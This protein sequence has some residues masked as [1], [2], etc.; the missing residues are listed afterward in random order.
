MRIIY[1]SNG[2]TSHDWNFLDKLSSSDNEVWFLRLKDRSSDTETRELPVGVNEIKWIG[3]PNNHPSL[4]QM[5]QLKC[6]FEKILVKVRPDIIH[7][8]PIQSCAF[9]AVLSGF[10]PIVATSWGYDILTDAYLSR[11]M[12]WITEYTLSHCD[13]ILCD[14]N[15]V[16]EKIQEFTNLDS[17]FIVQF[18]WG[19]KLSKFFPGTDSIE[20]RKRL[21]WE[22]CRVIISTRRWEPI[23][24]IKTVLESFRL[25][26]IKEP[27]LRLLLIGDG[28]L[29]NYVKNYLIK[30]GMGGVIHCPGVVNNDLLPKYFQVA[31]IYLSCSHTD[32]SSVSLLE[33]LASGIP[34]IVSDIPGNREWIIN[35]KIGGLAPAED[36]SIFAEQ[37]LT[38]ANLNLTDREISRISSRQIIESRGDWDR[39]FCRLLGLYK[40]VV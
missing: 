32:G 20:L 15:A 40:K 23:Y 22:N 19:V 11:K 36:A 16:K 1:F 18:P 12:N 10:H 33:A 14:S 29:L 6:S 5:V 34:A 37:I 24:G 7:A 17:H 13:A 26:Y 35:E 25:A 28:S 30:H 8:G 9:I 31:D 27:T 4:D 2:Y 21:G 3:L 39:N 38:Y